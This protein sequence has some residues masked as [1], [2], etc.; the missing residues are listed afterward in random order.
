MAQS[1][2]LAAGTTVATSSTVAVPPGGSVTLGL[3]VA[4]GD[5]PNNVSAIVRV[6]T[7]GAE[8]NIGSLSKQTPTFLVPGPCTVQV[9]RQEAGGANVGVYAESA[10]GQ[11]VEGNVASGTTDSGNPVKVGGVFNTTSPSPSTGQRVD[12]QVA[13]RG[14]LY[15]NVKSDVDA[16]LSRILTAAS[17]AAPTSDTGLLVNNR[18]FNFDGTQFTRQRGDVVATSVLPGL[19]STFWNYAAAAGGILNTT[20][21]VT[22]KAAAGASVRNYISSLELEWEALGA[23]TELAI[24]D[25]AAGTVIYRTKLGTAAGRKTINFPVPLRGTA[26]TLVE[27]VTL[28]ASVTGAVYA[29]LQGFTAA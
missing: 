1:T 14:S 2:I 23:A 3:F 17:D 25:G 26:N 21:A 19:S 9:L 12:L 13:S 18:N 10:V 6:T 27:V 5:I 16:N 24:R 29:N 20:T 7:P 28:T 11:P 8:V 22:V 4:S 15:V